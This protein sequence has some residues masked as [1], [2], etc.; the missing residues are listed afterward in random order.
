MKIAQAP[1]HSGYTHTSGSAE[2]FITT[3][4]VIFI[5][6]GMFFS[7]ESYFAEQSFAVQSQGGESTSIPP[8]G[9]FGYLVTLLVLGVI[10]IKHL[11]I[12]LGAIRRSWLPISFGV[13][14]LTSS[15]WASDVAGSANR[16]LRMMI[17]VLFAIYFVRCYND[18][19]RIAI[20][21]HAMVVAIICSVLAVIIIPKY[22]MSAI[23]GYTD[24]WRGAF[25]HKNTLGAVMA[26][27]IFIGYYALATRAIRSSTALFIM[28]GCFGLL[29]ASRSATSIVATI[30]TLP[31]IYGLG[32]VFLVKNISDKIL[33]FGGGLL[34]S[35]ALVWLIKDSNIAFE[36]LGRSQTLTG[37]AEVWQLT[38]AAI[39]ANPYFGYGHTFWS[40]PSPMRDEI[41][42][43]LT[44]AAPH[45][46]NTFLDIW[47]QM[48]ILGVVVYVAMMA[49]LIIRG[50]RI[51]LG[52][53]PFSVIL[54][55]ILLVQTII[56][57]LTETDLLDTAIN[58]MFWIT[59]I[60]AIF[61][62]LSAQSKAVALQNTAKST[63]K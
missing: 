53:M 4:I 48:G 21:A 16:S 61:A 17:V 10:Y 23:N 32:W 34:L 63:T 15:M 28:V 25:T 13:V 3:I 30:A 36:L 62:E 40:Y 51:I 38:Q 42:M 31:L 7:P 52:N 45:A 46:H 20:L 1:Q 12:M 50:V 59:V 56:R 5:M 57:S 33:L 60:Y 6:Y 14:A 9:R 43:R 39:E 54:W 8:I 22:G 11:N 37:R 24:A 41:W 26:A 44:W 55:I 19:E 18:K 27:G 47:L 58:G 35:G 2:R 49:K 29:I